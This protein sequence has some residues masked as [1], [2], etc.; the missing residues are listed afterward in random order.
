VYNDR[1]R[2]S[3][4]KFRVNPDGRAQQDIEQR[5]GERSRQRPDRT[6]KA[7]AT[8]GESSGSFKLGGR[9]LVLMSMVLVLAAAAIRIRAAHNDLWLDEIWS[10]NLA[11]SVSSPIGVFTAIHHDNNHYLNTLYLYFLPDRGNWW[12][13][14]I[15]SILFGIATVIV[16]GFVGN[17][18][19][20]INALI[21]MFLTAFSYFLVLYSSEARG[22]SAVVFFVLLS[23]LLLDLYL[24]K[25]GI[26]LAVLFSVTAAF[27]F[28]S[29]LTFL[30]FYLAA[31]VWSAYRLAV[32]RPRLKHF[33]ASMLSIHAFP[34]LVLA[35]LYFVDVRLQTAGGGR[36][37]FSAI[38]TFGEAFAWACGASGGNAAA[39]LLCIAIV[40]ALCYAYAF[41][42]SRRKGTSSW[43]V[44]IGSA[45]AIPFL[46]NLVYQPGFLYVRYFIVS[47]IFFLVLIS[48]CLTSLF[49]CGGTGRAICVVLL[50]CYCAANGTHIR[51]LFSYGRGQYSAAVRY[52]LQN[53]RGNAISVGGDHP[54]RIPTTLSFF[55]PAAGSA[56]QLTY[57]RT[58]QEWP[59]EGPEWLILHKGSFE[60]PTSPDQVRDAAGR[61]YD[62]AKI[63]P[64]A[65][66]SGLHWF[67]YHNAADSDAH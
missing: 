67:L 35:L 51:E 11:H 59:R 6:K 12:G 13:Y 44:P 36:T 39:L 54:F 45:I 26:R 3:K 15:L 34:G 14:R 2:K 9:A 33:A 43:L 1:V 52:M 49:E 24:E 61:R 56:K 28:L 42:S 50:A 66:L 32:Q 19:T 27:G 60:E 53:G 25:P 22:Y 8:R 18:R 58:P 23:F 29:H 5:G 40:A 47:M 10:L 41:G 7:E 38:G 20:R 55:A 48:L 62:L 63:F 31:L 21:L 37:D 57:Y 4:R 64:S 16:A 17:R 65:P 30:H 46:F